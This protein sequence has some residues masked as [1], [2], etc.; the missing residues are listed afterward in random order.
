MK[1][2]DCQK[3]QSRCFKPALLGALSVVGVFLL[4][5]F[6]AA[7]MLPQPKMETGNKFRMPVGQLQADAR[8]VGA[9]LRYLFEPE[10]NVEMAPANFVGGAG[11]LAGPAPT[12]VQTSES[13]ACASN[14]TVMQVTSST[15]RAASS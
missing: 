3:N 12:R 10:S 8:T 13:I 5:C 9:A 4:A 2:S 1:N 14:Q 7:L 6:G 15:N 11:N